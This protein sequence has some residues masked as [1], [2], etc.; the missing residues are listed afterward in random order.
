MPKS[1]KTVLFPYQVEGVNRIEDFGGRALLADSMGLGKTAQVLFWAWMYLPDEALKVV[2]C[3]ASIKWNWQ[4]EARKHLNQRSEVLSGRKPPRDFRF[5]QKVIYILNYDIIGSP[6]DPDSWAHRIKKAK[7][8]LL[9]LDECFPYDTEVQTDKGLMKIGEIVENQIPV[10]VASFD[11]Y[12]NAIDYKPVSHYFKIKRRTRLVTVK[13]EFGKL[14]CTE[15]HLI[16]TV[17]RGYVKAIELGPKDVLQLVQNDFLVQKVRNEVQTVLRQVVFGE[18]ENAATGNSGCG[19]YTG[20]ETKNIEREKRNSAAGPI[21]KNE[22]IQSDSKSGSNRKNKKNQKTKRDEQNQTARGKRYLHETTK[23]TQ[24]G[25]RTGMDSRTGNTD[26]SEKNERLSPVLQSRFGK[27][28]IQTSRGNRRKRAQLQEI[29]KIGQK[30]GPSSRIS[31]V[32]SV[33]IHEQRSGHPTETSSPENQFVYCLEVEKN[34]N[35]YANGVLVSNCHYCKSRDSQRT[36][37]C[38]KLAEKVPHVIAVSGTPITNRP[39]ELWPVLNILLPKHPMFKSFTR[40]ANRYCKPEWTRWGVKYTGAQR[41]D[42]LHKILK[43]SVMIRR[44]KAN[45]L[46]QLPAKTRVV[47]PLDLENAHEYRKAEADFV[48][49][50]RRTHPNKANK[51]RSAELLVKTGYL[52]RLVGELKLKAVRQWIADHLEESENKLIAFGVHK[53]VVKGIYESFGDRSVVVDGSVTGEKRQEAIDRFNS[54]PGVRL[55]VGNIQAA[56]VGWNGQ[57]ADSVAFAELDYVPANMI[58]AEDRAH[59]MGQKNPVTCYYLI[60][61]GTIEE[62]IAEILQKKQQIS[63]EALDGEAGVQQYGVLDQLEEA[64]LDQGT[65]LRKRK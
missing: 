10:K 41:L 2:I 18:V 14:T 7:P 29:Q 34:H 44:L 6:D 42:E 49:W 36:K 35:F 13:H 61:K 33:E 5:K 3:P 23:Q 17:N 11:F 60:G 38:R 15:E 32:D 24:I 31:R 27:K 59:R 52:R 45:V 19:V 63:D 51:A 64:L 39:V 43:R 16:W 57:I 26:I 20:M 50:L 56:G 46:K 30:E 1:D 12:S 22:A 28:K 8:E 55:F 40:F 21:N 47:V 65:K 58:Q 48:S 25:S 53:K 54:A 4:R 37:N 62:K 9:V